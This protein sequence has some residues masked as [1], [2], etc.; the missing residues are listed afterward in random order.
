MNLR[1]YIKDS[2]FGSPFSQRLLFYYFYR[3]SPKMRKCLKRL[4]NVLKVVF[5]TPSRVGGTRWVGHLLRAV[6]TFKKMNSSI[7]QQMED[8]LEQKSGQVRDFMEM[9]DKRLLFHSTNMINNK[10]TDIMLNKLSSSLAISI[11]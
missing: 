6:E 7:R 10:S 2:Y 8:I 1:H 11:V 9:C 4:C 5:L 3:N